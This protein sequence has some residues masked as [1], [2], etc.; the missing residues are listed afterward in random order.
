MA[1]ARIASEA[2]MSD[3]EER[4]EKLLPYHGYRQD[5]FPPKLWINCGLR[6]CSKTE[7]GA[8]VAPFQAY[9]DALYSAAISA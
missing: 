5:K 9:A 3:V 6:A 2:R 1:N 8:F 4:P 7:N